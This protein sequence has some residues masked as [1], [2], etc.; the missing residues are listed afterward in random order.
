MVSRQ[1]TLK[2]T[3]PTIFARLHFGQLISEFLNTYKRVDLDVNLSDEVSDITSQ[4]YDVAIRIGVIKDQG[5]LSY[6]L[7]SN[8]RVLC[9]HPSYLKKHGVPD[10]LQDLKKHNCLIL[11]TQDNWVL[12]GPNGKQVIQVTGNFKF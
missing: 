4:G 11:K 5:L 2:I 1:G 8:N 12:S 3:A 10:S 6:P 9:A 7:A